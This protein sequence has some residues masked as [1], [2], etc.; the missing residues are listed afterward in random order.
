MQELLIQKHNDFL[1]KQ[2]ERTENMD[3]WH[4]RRYNGLGGSDVG[5]ILGVNKYKTIH[6]L[7]EEKTLR[8][9]PPKQNHKMHFGHVLEDPIAKEFA[10]V[11]GVK[12]RI[13]N[14]QYKS[15]NEPWLLGNVD[16]LITLQDKSKAVLECK[17]SADHTAFKDGYIFR[18]GEFYNGAKSNSQS[19]PLTYYCQC[20]HYMYITGIH[21]CYLACLIDGNDFRV[22]EVL[23]NQ[24][25]VN[26]IVQKATEFWF[27]NIIEDVEPER[28]LSDYDNTVNRIDAVRLDSNKEIIA[29]NL[30]A[31]YLGCDANIKSLEK[32]RDEIKTNLLQLVDTDIQE[33]LDSTGNT[34][35]T[36]KSQTRNSFDKDKFKREHAD[37]YPSYITQTQTKPI[38]TIKG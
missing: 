33:V 13:S 3:D 25:D 11:M 4:K 16:R 24:S 36:I 2:N 28:K 31:E 37:L 10:R 20:Q 1:K 30:I 23:Y 9:E 18:N 29:K 26:E 17:N 34:L 15:E 21:K 7:W 35:Y 19:I 5:T 8:K 32:H 38:V 22:Y 6:E 27:N 14:K 12:I